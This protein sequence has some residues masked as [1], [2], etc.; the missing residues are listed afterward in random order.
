MNTPFND[1]DVKNEYNGNF[2][3]TTLAMGKHS[4]MTQDYEYASISFFIKKDVGIVTQ[5]ILFSDPYL[6]ETEKFTKSF[7]S[8]R[9]L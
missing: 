5:I 8:F 6:L 1:A 7:Y 4:E 2:G 3:F 9:F